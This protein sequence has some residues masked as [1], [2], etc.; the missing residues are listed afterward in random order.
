M[1]VYKKL[2]ELKKRK[3]WTNY[4][5]AKESKLPQ[6]TVDNIYNQ[7]NTPQIETLK[8]LCDGFG[9]T[10]S[11]FFLEDEK[12]SSLSKGQIEILDLYN[13]LS[14]EKKAAVKT[15]MIFIVW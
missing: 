8:L 10:L 14:D 3:N 12:N 6:S 9:I 4:K 5:I 1:D 15:I 11:Q 2:V 7:R 13:L